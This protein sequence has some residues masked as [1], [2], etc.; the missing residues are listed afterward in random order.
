MEKI[1]KSIL[2]IEDDP[3]DA[4][5]IRRALRKLN[6]STDLTVIE[7]GDAAIRWFQE[8]ASAAPE[9]KTN[10]PWIV[11]LDIKMPRMTGMEV[12]A[13][14][15]RQSRFC[16]LPV[17]AFTS[18][19]EPADIAQAYRLGV[20]SYLVKPL[21]FDQLKETIRMMHHYWMDLNERPDG[22]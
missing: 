4:A 14:V 3:N 22:G 21:S 6:L 16:H 17:I 1:R 20:N 13:W 12:L 5:L 7:D 10:W 15:R 11:L 19:R 8:K 9:K 18:S 2:L